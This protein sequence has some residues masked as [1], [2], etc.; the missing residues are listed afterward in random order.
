MLVLVDARLTTA[1]EVLLVLGAILWIVA[2]TTSIILI[3]IQLK[4][5]NGKYMHSLEVANIGFLSVCIDDMSRKQLPLIV[6]AR[7][8]IGEIHENPCTTNIFRYEV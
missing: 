7:Y 1:N 8:S 2:T 5:I 3:V 6:I 4:L